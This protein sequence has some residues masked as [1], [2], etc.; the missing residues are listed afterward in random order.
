VGPRRAL[1][2]PRTKPN[3]FLIR[4]PL[5]PQPSLSE[6]LLNGVNKGHFYFYQRLRVQFF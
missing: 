5:M 2:E 1:G 6:I 4:R 3:S